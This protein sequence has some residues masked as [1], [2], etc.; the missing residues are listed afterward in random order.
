MHEKAYLLF[1]Q[2]DDW[3]L[4]RVRRK[5]NISNNTLEVQD[6]HSTEWMRHS[7]TIE[8]MQPTVTHCRTDMITDCLNQDCQ[9]LALV[10]AGQALSPLETNAT[11]TSQGTKG[12]VSV[13]GEGSDKVNL[14]LLVPSLD[15]YFTPLK[16]KLSLGNM[17]EN[18]VS[19]DKKLNNDKRTEDFPP[20]LISPE[21]DLN[22]CSQNQSQDGIHNPYPTD[23][24]IEFHELN[25]WP[26]H[27]YA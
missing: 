4:C 26:S 8:K 11:A 23:S 2:L 18:L 7:P 25:N 15:N 3:V 22:N 12:F 13:S 5:G 19:C 27:V 17:Q 1:P 24:V 20:F 6:S 10:L 9:V 14:P 21:N 16:R